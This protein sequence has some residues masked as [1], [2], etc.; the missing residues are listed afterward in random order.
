MRL[1]R[2]AADSGAAI[3]PHVSIAMGPQIAAAIHFAAAA[4]ECRLVEYNPQVFAVANRF[5]ERP[6]GLDGT[7]YTVPEEPGL[8]VSV[9]MP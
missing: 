5:L 3:V 7:S 4:P 8:G 9:Q 1:A 6:L 2:L